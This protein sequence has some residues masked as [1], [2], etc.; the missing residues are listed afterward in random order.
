ME[1][2]SHLPLGIRNSLPR[3]YFMKTESIEKKRNIKEFGKSF[4]FCQDKKDS[5]TSLIK[6]ILRLSRKKQKVYQKFD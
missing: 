4:F 1:T 5:S 6:T 2:Y 3:I